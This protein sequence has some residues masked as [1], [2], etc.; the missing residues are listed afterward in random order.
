LLS[1]MVMVDA[2]GVNRKYLNAAETVSCEV[3]GGT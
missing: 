3:A 2:P 1:L